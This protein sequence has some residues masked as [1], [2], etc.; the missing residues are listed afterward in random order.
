MF[1][2]FGPLF[3]PGFLSFACFLHCDHLGIKTTLHIGLL[4]NGGQTKEK[5]MLSECP[6]TVLILKNLNI[7]LCSLYVLEFLSVFSTTVAQNGLYTVFK[8]QSR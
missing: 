8:I 4:R 1:V 3:S 5:S 2:E 7:N 6:I